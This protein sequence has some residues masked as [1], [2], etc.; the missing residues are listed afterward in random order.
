MHDLRRLL[1]RNGERAPGKNSRN[2]QYVAHGV[3][4]TENKFMSNLHWA[5]AA[6]ISL[7]SVALHAQEN[8]PDNVWSGNV[9]LVTD[10]SYRGISQTRLQPALQGG[11]DYVNNPTG[12]YAG[13]CLSNITWITD[14]GGDAKVEDDIYAGKRGSLG[15]NLSYDVGVLSYIYPDNNLHPNANTTEFYVQLNYQSAYAKYSQ[16][17]TNLFGFA[18]SRNSGYIDLGE[19]W[20]I[21]Q[22]TQLNLHVGH[23]SVKNNTGLGYNDWKIGLTRKFS[24]VSASIAAVGTNTHVYVG[25]PPECENLGKVR[26]ILLFSKTF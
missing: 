10:Y 17:A 24:F 20:D 18:D 3:Y 25:P 5:V 23:Q 7:A 16:S 12:F 13:T 8:K 19:N 4:K 21:A 15:N 2:Y 26:L 1:P 11:V 14:Q 6:A 9:S 22:L